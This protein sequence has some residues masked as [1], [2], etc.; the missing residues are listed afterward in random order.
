MLKDF[1]SSLAPAARAGFVAGV[2]LVVTLTAGAAAWVLR[3]DYQVLFTDLKPQD[4]ALMV[5]ELDRMKVPY[6]IGADGNT[7]SVDGAVVHATRLKLMGKDIPL[8]GAAGFELFNNADFGMTEFAQKVNYQRALQGEITRTILALSEV[9]DARV[10][11]AMP[12]EG[13]FK[14]ATSRAKAAITLSLKTGQSL[15]PEQITGIQRLVA[16]AVP[17]IVAQ[18]VTIVDRQGVALTR[19][20]AAEGEQDGAGSNRLDLKRDTER[21]LARKATEVLEGAFGSGQVLASVDVTLNMDLVRVTTEDVIG[22]PGRSGQSSAGVIVRERESARDV[23]PPLGG[24]TDAGGRASNSQREVEYQVGR[25]VEQVATQPGAIRRLQVVA[26]VRQPMD[27]KQIEQMRTLVAA[28]VGAMPERGDSVV[29]QSLR[30][31]ETPA[32][33]DA[34]PAVIEERAPPAAKTPNWPDIG[35]I[36]AL[37]TALAL[38]FILAAMVLWRRA[39]SRD[40]GM[41]ADQRQLLLEQMRQW[42][43]A[44]GTQDRAANG[45]PA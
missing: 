37:A 31:F 18:D 32:L 11:L 9:R 34:P 7:I 21:L 23:G 12:E 33:Q 44:G 19:V 16:A 22:A 20:T 36:G 41:S 45:G 15:R 8:H 35:A 2:V 17:G 10:H 29:V 6:R 24:R 43:D 42:L 30:A 27:D 25:R 3:T 26:V 28:A 4:T 13:L 39:R 14:R 40:S 1:W 5:A 38:S